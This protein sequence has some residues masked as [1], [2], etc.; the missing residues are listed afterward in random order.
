MDAES[1]N[2]EH[3]WDHRRYPGA[4]IWIS[5]CMLCRTINVDDLNEQIRDLRRPVRTWIRKVCEHAEVTSWPFALRFA[6]RRLARR[7]RTS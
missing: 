5:T 2:C 7:R 6:L 1:A 4:P 3:A